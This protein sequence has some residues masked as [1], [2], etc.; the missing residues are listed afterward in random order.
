M[1]GP[2][3]G[4]KGIRLHEPHVGAVAR[5]EPP[6]SSQSAPC[7]SGLRIS[8]ATVQR[9][10]APQMPCRRT[11]PDRD[12]GGGRQPVKA[13]ICPACVPACTSPWSWRTGRA[14]GR[15]G[16]LAE[17]PA[18]RPRRDPGASRVQSASMSP[19]RCAISSGSGLPGTSQGWRLAGKGDPQMVIGLVLPPASLGGEQAVQLSKTVGQHGEPV[20]WRKRRLILAICRQKRTRLCAAGSLTK[21]GICA[22]FRPLIRAARHGEQ[23]YPY[24]RNPIATINAILQAR[25]N[26]KCSCV[27][28][29]MR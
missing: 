25:A 4:G 14:L 17:G 1:R 13:S 20:L 26:A 19:S 24:K 22:I 29:N 15:K 2:G 10:Q 23:L 9:H 16:K 5:G 18:T 6:P 21:A 11:T 27:A 12:L 7:H 3:L 8:R 28:Q